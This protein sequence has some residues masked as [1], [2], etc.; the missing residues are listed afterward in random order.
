MPAL[1]T[2]YLCIN[3]HCILAISWEEADFNRAEV[4]GLILEVMKAARIHPWCGLCGST[5]LH[6]ETKA[7][8]GSVAETLPALRAC[9]AAQSFTREFFPRPKDN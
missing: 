1:L 6:F 9:E 4:E 5:K 2:Q 7:L 3:R 8:P